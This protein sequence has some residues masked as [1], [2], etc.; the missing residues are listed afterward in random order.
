[1]IG[2]QVV[3][4]EQVG[5]HG[6]PRDLGQLAL[7]RIPVLPAQGLVVLAVRPGDVVVRVPLFEY[8]EVAMSVLLDHGFEL[9]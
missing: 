1:M 5:D 4:G 3:L 8:A 6:H 9:V 7:L 2:G